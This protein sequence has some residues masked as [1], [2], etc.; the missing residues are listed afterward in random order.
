MA[1][2]AGVARVWC[3]TNGLLS[4]PATSA[5]IRCRG[6]K[7]YEPFGGRFLASD[8]RQIF[9]GSRRGL[10]WLWHEHL[11]YLWHDI[12]AAI[13][14]DS[15]KHRN[16]RLFGL[17]WEAI[18]IFLKW[19]SYRISRVES[20]SDVARFYLL[21]VTQSWRH[22]QWLWYQVPCPQAQLLKNMVDN[23]LE[24]V[25]KNYLYSL[26]GTGSKGKALRLQFLVNSSFQYLF[27]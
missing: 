1:F 10:Y 14:P 19:F 6:G 15:C 13:C 22:W 27:C 17:I 3:G 7:G 11:F 16:Q 25:L 5:V 21:C 2:A 23:E 8:F 20:L 24:K 18:Y 26:N 9:V 4:T 12:A